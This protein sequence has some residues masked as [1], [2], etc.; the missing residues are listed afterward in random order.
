MIS[1]IATVVSEWLV[2]QGAVT[3]KDKSLFAYAVYSFLFGMTPIVIIIVLGFIFDMLAEGLLLITPFMLL[4]KF[5]GGYHLKSPLVCVVTSTTLL[6][7]S[8]LSV[9]LIISSKAVIILSSLVMLATV[10]LFSLSPIDSEARRL[11]KKETKTFRL[12]ARAIAILFLVIY[13]LLVL[14]NHISIAAPIG[15]GVVIPAI[16]QLP[17]VIQRMIAKNHAS[18]QSQIGK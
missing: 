14:F 8:L 2:A 6:T 5:S 18:K 1:K 7:L 15:V 11:S 12:I 10:T 16:L 3:D 9:R 17:C 4:R 13:L